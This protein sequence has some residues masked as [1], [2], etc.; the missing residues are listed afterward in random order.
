MALS[1]E[2]RIVFSKKIVSAADELAAIDRAKEQLLVVK[3]KALEVDNAHKNLFDSKN[4]LTTGYENEIKYLDGNI[5]ISPTETDFQNSANLLA[6]NYFYPV[7]LGS[8]PPSISTPWNKTKP[9][10]LNIAIGKKYNETYDTTTTETSLISTITSAISSIETTYLA[11]QRVTGQT[12]V[13]NPIPPPPTDVISTLTALHTALSNLKTNIQ[14][15]KT[16]LQT[17]SSSIYILDSNTTRKNES[18]A[19]KNNIDS[20]VIP[21]INL[22]LSYVDFNTAHGQTT[23]SGFFSYDPNS[24]G[25]TKLRATELNALKTAISNRSAFILTRISQ[26]TG[27]FG[28]L[29]Q[30]LSTGDVTGSGLYYE[31]YLTINLR[32]NLLNGSL[33]E[34]NS[35]DKAI[36]AQQDQKS[37]I[38]SAVSTYQSV[39]KAAKFLSPA[40]NTEYV[41]MASVDNFNVGDQVYMIT[42]TQEEIVRNIIEI[43]GKRI[44]FSQPVPSKYREND[45]GRI[46][47]DA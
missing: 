7:T 17:E 22:W 11:I 27:Y 43:N 10:A 9:Y 14:N 41:Q 34:Y 25:S 20:I 37:A 1:K 31:R 13:T 16:F 29:S 39:I 26:L 28:T 12:C 35:F 4:V 33:I 23:C 5:R 44:R 19:A 47:K 45:Y 36:S 15:W 6:G 46:Y 21:A 40:T 42:D 2:D 24:L 18:I 8:L 30:D 32:L 38:N 3:S